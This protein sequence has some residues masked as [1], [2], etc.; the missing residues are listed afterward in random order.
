VSKGTLKILT[1]NG[2]VLWIDSVIEEEGE[3]WCDWLDGKEHENPECGPYTAITSMNRE[4]I[5]AMEWVE[6][7]Y[8]GQEDLIL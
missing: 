7:G 5:V 8:E 4:I 6:Y 1:T 3:S 2:E